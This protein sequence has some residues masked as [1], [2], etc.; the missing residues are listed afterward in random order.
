VCRLSGSLDRKRDGHRGVFSR[1]TAPLFPLKAA[2]VRADFRHEKK[3][4]EKGGPS[5]V[6]LA[7]LSYM[8]V[9]P[10]VEDTTEFRM[11]ELCESVKR[12]TS[13]ECPG[14]NMIEAEVI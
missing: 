11:E 3:K 12:M 5:C 1:S 9:H 6:V 4:K 13:G 2:G 7:S 10:N 14:P 8:A